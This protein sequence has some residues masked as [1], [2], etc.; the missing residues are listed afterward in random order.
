MNKHWE[1]DEFYE[2]LNL[3]FTQFYDDE[4]IISFVQDKDDNNFFIYVS[5]LL[6]VE[7]DYL[8]SETIEE[9]KEECEYKVRE[10]IQ[11]QVSYYEDMLEKFEE[12]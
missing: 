9:A 2:S 3:H 5:N 6:N 11:D 8:E 7:Y 12:E 10:Y 1:Y 4:I